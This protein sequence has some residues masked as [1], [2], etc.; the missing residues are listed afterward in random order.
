[1]IKHQLQ[2]VIE[3]VEKEGWGKTRE[4]NGIL[5]QIALECLRDTFPNKY[6]AIKRNRNGERYIVINEFNKR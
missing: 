6:V 5:V 3:H 1:M 4:L 2:P